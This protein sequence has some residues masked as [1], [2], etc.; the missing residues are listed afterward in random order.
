MPASRP[1]FASANHLATP[2]EFTPFT[3]RSPKSRRKQI[4]P[5]SGLAEFQWTANQRHDISS[6][7]IRNSELGPYFIYTVPAQMNNAEKY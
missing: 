5:I 1:N 4:R 3:N 6:Y 7:Y 2:H